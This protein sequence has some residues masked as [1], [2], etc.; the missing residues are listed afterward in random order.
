MRCRLAVA[1][2]MLLLVCSC[3]TPYQKHGL[4]GGYRERRIDGNTWAVSCDGNSYT[5]REQLDD[6]VIHRC[7]ELAVEQEADYFVLVRSISERGYA[8]AIV[9]VFKGEP[10]SG[11][12]AAIKA[13]EVLEFVGPRVR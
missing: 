2:V 8:S 7:A 12:R 1:A 10:P 5:R 11:D 3:A 13:R 4:R 6:Y 9:K